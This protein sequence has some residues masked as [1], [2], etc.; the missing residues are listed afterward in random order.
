VISKGQNLVNR[1]QTMGSLTRL[2][3]VALA[4]LAVLST[5]SAG[6]NNPQSGW[7]SGNP[8]LGPYALTDLACEGTTCYASGDGGTV[9]KSTDGGSTWSGIVTG[10]TQDLRRVQLAGGSADSI[11][12]GG[13][14]AVRRSDD[15]GQTFARLPFTASDTN[16]PF[17]LTALSFPSATVGYLALASSA[18]LSTADRGRTFSRK[19]TI[20]GGAPLDLLCTSE[21]T[22]LAV[23]AGG[24][25]QRT[26]DGASSWTQV[27]SLPGTA[28]RALQA[29]SG[30]TLYAV[31]D[32][33]AVMKSEDGGGKWSRVP[34]T[35]TPPGNLVSIRCSGI[36]T[37]L[38]ATATGSQ[39]LR[40]DDGG[41]SFKSL[42]PSTDPTR[43]VAFASATRAVAVGGQGSAEVSSDAGVNWTAVGTRIAGGFRVLEPVSASVAYAGGEDG[44]LARTVDGGR[45][46]ANVSAPTAA[47]IVGIAA[48]AAETVF[49][50]ANDG[51]LQRSDNGGKSYK[52]LNTG[53]TV[54]PAAIAALDG[55]RILLVGPRG[56]RR[57]VNGGDSFERVGGRVATGA[58]VGAVDIAGTAVLAYGA[59]RLIAS[60]DG[61]QTWKRLT[62]P[63]RSV[64][65]DVAFLSA[66][67]GYLVDTR[68]RVWRTANAGKTWTELRSLGSRVRLIEFADARSGYAIS[69]G[70]G[71]LRTTDRGKSW[72][73]QF[74]GRESITDI[75]TAGPTD[76]ALAGTSTLY[77]TTSGG[78]T[79][80][81]QA[82]SITAKPRQI[83][84]AARVT[85]S[86]KLSPADGGEEVYVA[87]RR[88]STWFA[89]LATV[90][91]NGTFVTKWTVSRTSVFVAQILG[92]ADHAGAGTMPLTVTVKPTSKRKR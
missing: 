72:H 31:G 83:R 39:V 88:G 15:G 43:A 17:A 41:K 2:A 85:V 14:C 58:A 48:P 82:L 87:M 34:V 35:G 76:Y 5:A 73:P 80:G 51:G 64:V 28:L 74:L 62:L 53:S 11:V 38:I 47:V 52:I 37:C 30:T 70:N 21:K 45:M 12:I 54:A 90:A 55:D 27:G 29:A 86:G 49:V 32:N 77:A 19:T 91:S 4:A 68:G 22:C 46:W 36:D 78:D 57:S 63:G 7:Y 8:L 60:S 18:V 84:K 81:P 40:T 20:P 65:R 25:I 13:D 1:R 66:R 26:T 44:V 69:G 23:T 10:I 9:L 71:V 33:L 42:V 16:C 6:V 59:R 50:L 24:S 89:Q 92:D 56:I 61:G 79:G 67:L 75:R 3:C